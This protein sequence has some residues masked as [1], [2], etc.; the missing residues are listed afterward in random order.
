MDNHVVSKCAANWMKLGKYLNIEEH[1][2]KI[3]SEDN[4]I[5]CERICSKMLSDWLDMHAVASWGEL[6]D[7][8][9]KLMDD[10]E[11]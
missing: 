3:I 1:L 4:L 5:D 9:D 8:V 2:L 10:E 7:A 11:G 6:I